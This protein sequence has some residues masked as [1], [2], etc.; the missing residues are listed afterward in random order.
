MRNSSLSK[1]KNPKILTKLKQVG[2]RINPITI[3]SFKF[4]QTNHSSFPLELKAFV[5]HHTDTS[6]RIALVT[7]GGTIVPLEKNTVR[8]LDNF[9]G[10]NRGAA[11][12][13]Y[14]L[15]RKLVTD[16]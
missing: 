10:G 2:Q 5:Q 14:L 11:A 16:D 13:E 8:F 1:V 3:Y 15:K 6:R 12:V 4:I 9:S 7:S